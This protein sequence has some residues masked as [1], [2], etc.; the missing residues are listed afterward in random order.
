MPFCFFQSNVDRAAGYPLGGTGDEDTL[1]RALSQE[2]LD[3]ARTNYQRTGNT[4]IHIIRV[5]GAN[6]L[7]QR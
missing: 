5:K 7:A 3:I 4:L 6:K 1:S 2:T